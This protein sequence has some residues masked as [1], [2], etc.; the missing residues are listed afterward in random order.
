VLVCVLVCVCEQ[1][2]RA[3]AGACFTAGREIEKHESECAIEGWALRWSGVKTAFGGPGVGGRA[4]AD[5]ASYNSH[6]AMRAAAA[7]AQSRCNRLCARWH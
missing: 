3:R 1:R 5:A 7:A 6:H 4:A 2:V